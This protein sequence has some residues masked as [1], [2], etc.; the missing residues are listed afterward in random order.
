MLTDLRT[1]LSS[2]VSSFLLGLFLILGE[3]KVG[4]FGLETL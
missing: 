1:P 3:A 2:P 4:M